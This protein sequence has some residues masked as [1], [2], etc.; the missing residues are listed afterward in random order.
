MSAIRNV[1][2]FAFAVAVALPALGQQATAPGADKKVELPRVTVTA[3]AYT[4]SHGGYLVSGDFKVDPRMPTVV[5]PATA[6]VKDDV[7]SVQP[8]HLNDN[9]YVVLQECASADCSDARI[10]RVWTSGDNHSISGGNDQRITIP[11]ENKYWIWAKQLP[12]ISRPDCET[13]STHFVSF[14]RFGP[15]MTISPSGEEARYHQ[16]EL[17]AFANRDP[18]PVEKQ[19][20]DGSTFVVTFVGGSTVRVRRM[21]ADAAP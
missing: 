9:E 4:E 5:Y 15:P 16:P 12:A 7:I 21:H 14:N 20:H 2:A 6:L 3:D 13:C 11:H 8:Q 18:L 17:D 10:V 1:L 19:T